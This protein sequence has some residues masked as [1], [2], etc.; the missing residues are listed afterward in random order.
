MKTYDN[1]SLII[2][3][4]KLIPTRNA[5]L[6]GNYFRCRRVFRSIKKTKKWKDTSS[7]DAL[8]PD[9]YSDKYKLMME[10]MAINDVEYLKN[11]KPINEQR[12]R[13]HELLS[14]TFGI[15]YKK[16]WND[17]NLIINNDDSLD[18][19]NME[20]Y[21]LSFERVVE[22]HRGKVEKYKM[23]HEGYELIFFI[24]DNS[25]AYYCVIDGK[26]VIH[27]PLNDKYF[28][29]Y[30]KKLD[31][32]YVVW[33]TSNKN[34]WDSKNKFVRLPIVGIYDVKNM[35]DKS[36]DYSIYDLKPYKVKLNN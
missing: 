22:K 32:D 12:S 17:V 18:N 33:F 13:Q 8:P 5:I 31:V 9:F 23:N 15:D 26:T 25:P 14:K 29:D 21:K 2:E 11:G 30:I 35:G 1:E 4:F 16:V 7:K 27:T 36:V 20:S 28:V 10:M 6:N 34:I 19:H 24:F 3:K